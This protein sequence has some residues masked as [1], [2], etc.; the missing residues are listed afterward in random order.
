MSVPR[1]NY[2]LWL[3]ENRESIKTMY[4]LDYEI[5]IVDGK[6]ENI[7]TLV[8]KKAGEVWRSLDNS[9]KDKYTEK[10]NTLKSALNESNTKKTS[11]DAPPPYQ[12]IKLDELKPKP[13]SKSKSKRKNIPKTIRKSVWNKFIETDDPDK[14]KGKCFV[15]CNTKINIDNFELGHIISHSN[16]GKDNI[17]NLRPICSLC[18]KSMGT[19][20]LLDFKEQYGL[21]NIV[22]PTY[23]INKLEECDKLN[24]SLL[25]EQNPILLK[26]NKLNSEIDDITNNNLCLENISTLNQTKLDQNNVDY[27]EKVKELKLKLKE[28]DSQHV[29]EIKSINENIKQDLI[30][31]NSNIK[32]LDSLRLT[33]STN[34]DLILI[35]KAKID[36]LLETQKMYQ[37]KLS[38]IKQQELEQKKKLELELELEVKEE[39]EREAL[40][41]QIKTRLLNDMKSTITG[42][43]LINLDS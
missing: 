4:F 8:T 19:Q 31:I 34:D 22:D 6:K 42:E 35:N 32:L 5:K 11:G 36:N 20:N 24:K 13:K 2:F 9:I 10:L 28:L 1:N 14:L 43:N 30:K 40:K 16:G 21:S 38:V 15:G 37:S 17:E 41:Q 27:Q 25:E 23:F 3:K 39:L 33:I 26:N 18:N 29:L 7:S 12:D